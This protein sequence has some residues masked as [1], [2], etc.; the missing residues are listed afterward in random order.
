M[1]RLLPN[2]KAT[3][4]KP[5]QLERLKKLAGE[6]QSGKYGADGKAQ[7]T[8]IRGLAKAR[9]KAGRF[10]LYTDQLGRRLYICSP[11]HVLIEEAPLTFD[12]TKALQF[13]DGF[14]DPATKIG[15]WEMTLRSYSKI[16]LTLSHAKLYRN[17]KEE[18]HNI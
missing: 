5:A 14:D 17:G 12:L 9:Q 6:G 15:G 8:L 1:K 7:L 3:K 2:T 16:P 11:Y 13:Y 18:K 10:V 4:L